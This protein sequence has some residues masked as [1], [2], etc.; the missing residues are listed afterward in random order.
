MNRFE[1]IGGEWRIISMYT[2]KELEKFSN[3]KIINGDENTKINLFS[4]SR[5]KHIKGEFYIPIIFKN[6]NREIFIIN[7]VRAGG[8]GFMINKDSENYNTIINEAKTINP[9]TCILEVEDS[10]RVLHR[11]GLKTRE[12]NIDKPVVAVTGSVG[13]TTLCSLI[14]S[15][16]KKQ[17]KVLHDEENDNNNT[18][19]FISIDLLNTKEYDIAVLELGTATPGSM[20]QLS[21]L[22]K[23]SIAIINS[24]GT[25]H[26]N[27]F[28]TK[29]NILEEKLHITD[30]LKDDKILFIN[31]DN[32]LLSNVKDNNNY[33]TI[34]YSK[35]EASNIKENEHGISFDID[36][37]DKNTHFDLNLYG[38]HNISNI[39][40][41]IKIAQHY[42]IEY[43]NIVLA[44]REF[45]AINGRFKVLENEEKGIKI[46]DDSYS[47]SLES[48]KEGLIAANKI[49]SDR[50]IAVLGKMA[51]LGEQ[52]SEL[53]EELGEFFKEVNFDYIY[54]TGEYTKH[55][56]K[57]ALKVLEEKN[58]K[59]FKTKESLIAELLNNIQSG[60]L[61]YVKAAQTQ[62][63]E[64]IVQELK[65]KYELK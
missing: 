43:D 12:E 63:F 28:L 41:A 7:S 33:K 5:K 52:S 20:T 29:E 25:A 60:D 65:E 36:I 34:R 61:V 18:Y 51:A 8:K 42:K 15:I 35:N 44:I 9:N 56:F 53:H 2:L 22:V 39:V 62:N 17:Y 37:Y 47:S 50:K 19:S 38:I 6:I 14:A 64:S 57:G 23:P 4:T 48:V 10:K 30:Y 26:L 40:L 55:L 31:S 49:K 24:I 27:K 1:T 45:K 54:M 13:K 21:E 3:G 16:L 32:E 59:R 11:L 58:I 46:I